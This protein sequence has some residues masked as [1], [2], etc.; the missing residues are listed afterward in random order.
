MKYVDDNALRQNITETK[1]Y[2]DTHGFASDRTPVGTIISVGCDS[3]LIPSSTIKYPTDDYFICKGTTL[4]IAEYPALADYFEDAFG[5]KNYFGGDGTTTFKVPDFTTDF[6]TNGILAIKAQMTSTQITYAEVNDSLTTDSNV[7]SAEKVNDTTN[8]I[9]TS[10]N[11]LSTTV[12]GLS[13]SVSGLSTSVNGLSTTVSGHTSE[14]ST[15]T[16][17]KNKALMIGDINPSTINLDTKM[18]KP[19]LKMHWVNCGLA[20]VTGTKPYS[21]NYGYM[22]HFS[23]A[24]GL[25]ELQVFFPFDQTA[26]WPVKYRIT[27]NNQWYPWRE[28]KTQIGERI[29]STAPSDYKTRNINT[30]GGAVLK[31]LTV[32]PGTWILN[33]GFYFSSLVNN[34]YLSLGYTTNS[35]TNMGSVAGC[36]NSQGAVTKTILDGWSG[37]IG[38]SSVVTVTANTTYYVKAISGGGGYNTG[39]NDFYAIRLA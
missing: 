25:S 8:A 35:G 5:S 10:V 29:N 14:L 30:T 6:P 20:T 34:S 39:S 26:K 32:T 18:D 11:G 16:D 31:Q 15:L 2:V 7:W 13:T 37:I 17:V 4:N 28:F 12:N 23:N 27:A 1:N 21:S 33:L 38:M 22:L 19:G 9:S 3:S 36:N 24:N